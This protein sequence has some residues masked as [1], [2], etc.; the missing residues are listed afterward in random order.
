MLSVIV[1]QALT[2]NHEWRPCEVIDLSL[3]LAGFL[4]KKTFLTFEVLSQFVV[5]NIMANKYIK[6]WE[7]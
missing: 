1:M 5:S 7:N 2:M 3:V 6:C 4:I